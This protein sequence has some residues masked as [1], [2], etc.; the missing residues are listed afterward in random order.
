MIDVRERFRIRH[1]LI[2]LI[3]WYWI[4]ANLKTY[5]ITIFILTTFNI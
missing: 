4:W 5:T 3:K 2:A 1:A